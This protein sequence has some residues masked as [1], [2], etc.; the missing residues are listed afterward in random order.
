[1]SVSLDTLLTG[2]TPTDIVI[3]FASGAQRK[4]PHQIEAYCGVRHPHMVTCMGRIAALKRQGIAIPSLHRIMLQIPVLQNFVKHANF[5]QVRASH[6]YT[7][8]ACIHHD[9]NIH[10]K[11]GQMQM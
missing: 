7:P 10:Q 8:Y 11:W 6:I 1:M 3:S 5:S 4:S 9:L 2:S